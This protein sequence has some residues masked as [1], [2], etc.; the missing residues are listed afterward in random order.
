[1]ELTERSAETLLQLLH[2]AYNSKY[3]SVAR[4]RRPIELLL[5]ALV[6]CRPTD[7][8]KKKFA[9]DLMES[10]IK[11]GKQESAMGEVAMKVIKKFGPGEDQLCTQTVFDN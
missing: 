2:D 11:T 8:D 1:L 9:A 3:I 10:V 5:K 6:A 7:K 4:Q